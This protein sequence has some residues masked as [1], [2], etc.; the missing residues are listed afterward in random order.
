M[1]PPLVVKET[2]CVLCWG[3]FAG[4]PPWERRSVAAHGGKFKKCVL[5]Y[6]T[7]HRQLSSFFL[8]IKIGP[9]KVCLHTCSSQIPCFGVVVRFGVCHQEPYI[10]V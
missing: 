2:G 9:Q 10:Y 8:G 4:R 1:Q 5:A 3:S 7:D 6:E